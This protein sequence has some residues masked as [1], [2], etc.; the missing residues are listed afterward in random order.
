MAISNGV[1]K[2][3]AVFIILVLAAVGWYYRF[4]AQKFFQSLP[5]ISKVPAVSQV[6]QEISA[7]PP[8]IGTR[9]NPNSS[10]TRVGV[11]SWTNTNRQKNG[12]LRALTENAQL[13]KAAQ[14]KLADMFKQQYFEHVNPQGIGPSDLAK[15]AGY[16]FITE[17]ENL[18]LGNFTDDQDLLTAWMN[19]PGHRANILN[20]KFEEIGVAVGRGLYEGH[21]T[22]LAVQ[23]FGKPAGSCPSVNSNLKANIDNLQAEVNQLQPQLEQVKNQL[24]SANPKTQRDYDAYNNLVAQYNSLVKIYN[25]KV[26]SLKLITGQYNGEVKNYN[27]CLGS[28]S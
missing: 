3:F 19:S 2:I 17:G 1:K 23:E 28:S 27:A 26:D 8:L 4:S 24:D 14:L 21:Q 16:N 15:Q 10:L 7:P 22:W 18:A 9:D 20:T 13:D 11:I 25:N 6:I 5:E 12:G